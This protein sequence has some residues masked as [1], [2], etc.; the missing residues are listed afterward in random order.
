[1]IDG[2]A[3][4]L[5]KRGYIVP[6][7]GDVRIEGFRTSLA[8]VATFRFSSVDGSYAGQKGKARNVGVIAVAIFE[9]EAPPPDQ[10]IVSPSPYPPYQP[11]DW[12]DD[13][14]ARDSAPTTSSG[15]AASADHHAHDQ[16]RR[17]EEDAPAP[18]ASRARPRPR[19]AAMPAPCGSASPRRR[20]AATARRSTPT[21]RAVMAGTSPSPRRLRRSA[22]DAPSGL[23]TEFGETRYSAASYT[24]FVRSTQAPIAVAE[25]RYN[26]AAGL[27]ALGIPVEPT[28]G[29]RRGHAARDRGPV[30]RRSLRA[31]GSLAALCRPRYSRT[32]P[33]ASI[34]IA[35]AA[36]ARARAAAARVRTTRRGSQQAAT[37]GEIARAGGIWICALCSRAGGPTRGGAPRGGENADV[38]ARAR[39]RSC[40]DRRA[41]PGRA[42]GR[43]GTWSSEALFE[44]RWVA[45]KSFAQ[46]VRC[47]Q[48]SIGFLSPSTQNGSRRAV[49]ITESREPSK[50]IVV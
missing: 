49:H 40:S 27:M 5:R 32:L 1:M 24:R 36:L 33:H 38:P 45:E 31:P 14:D 17:P 19:A 10:Q 11:Y 26:D 28:A 37:L 39:R 46:G 22:A 50:T 6:A 41:H 42:T 4:D 21:R 15:S 8:D 23:G 43:S 12:T 2:D 9:E 35:G 18:S 29:L 47:S 20:R 7:Y 34:E 3:G 48:S 16:G 44:S 25:L 13:L 30:P